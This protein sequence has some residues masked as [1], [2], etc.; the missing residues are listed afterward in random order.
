[1]YDCDSDNVRSQAPFV[2]RLH[3][4]ALVLMDAH[5][6][7]SAAEVM[8]LLGGALR[9]RRAG[10]PLAELQAYRAARAAAGSTHCD[11]D[12]GNSSIYLIYCNKRTGQLRDGLIFYWSENALCIPLGSGKNG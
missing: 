3:V 10:P 12:P 6:H 5:A 8:G 11:M 7:A 9:A 2:V 1:M 4:S